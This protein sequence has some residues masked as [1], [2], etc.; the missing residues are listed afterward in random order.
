MTFEELQLNPTL[1][2][3]L[4]MMGF[5]NPTPIQEQAIP[6]IL[7]GKDL[8]ACA[9]TGT[10]K[11]GA[12]LLPIIHKIIDDPGYDHIDTLIITPTREL[13]QQIDQQMEGLGYYGGISSVAVYGGGD[14]S[15]F[16]KERK[17]LSEGTH[18]VVG[19]PGRLI[20]HLN[21]GYVKTGKIRHLILDEAD[22]ML[23]MGFNE[24]IMK[25][26]SHLPK[27]RQT[28]M[29]S[30]TMPREIRDLARKVMRED[31]VEISLA[32]SKPAEGV[33]QG[34]FFVYDNQKIELIKHLLTAR[35][36]TTVIVFSATK[37]NV[38]EIN[39]TLKK[40][41][42]NSEA[43]HSDLEQAEREVVLR[44]FKNREIT[45]LVAT[46]IMSR[47]IDIDGIEIVINF[48]APN[49]GEDYIHRIG[50]TARAAS[51]GI[52]FTFVNE[53]DMGKLK[54]IERLLEKEIPRIKNP[55]HV[56]EGPEFRPGASRSN[57]KFSGNRPFNPKRSGK[58]KKSR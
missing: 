49:E 44:R 13:A 54:T 32:V 57:G 26:I 56:G 25:I 39:K 34:V 31:P 28:L 43:I 21:M 16:E 2:N 58:F 51:K 52:A 10:G 14:G 4:E 48:D 55:E 7:D 40:E 11:T 41:G 47:G 18:V 50:R 15:A 8:I 30:A 19:T 5:K 53:K 27:V 9:Q 37:S 3:S 12:F 20:S 35:K 46:D 29:F 1:L 6:H 23:D 38:K 33:L 24:D 22:R 45:V 17:A 42:V 36:V